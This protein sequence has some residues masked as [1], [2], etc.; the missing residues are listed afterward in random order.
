[1]ARGKNP[2]M[3]YYVSARKSWTRFLF[4]ASWM[5]FACV[6]AATAQSMKRSDSG[7]ACK[8]GKR[9]IVYR[10][11]FELKRKNYPRNGKTLMQWNEIIE[12]LLVTHCNK[13]C[14]FSGFL[15]APHSLPSS[16]LA[17]GKI[18]RTYWESWHRICNIRLSGEHTECIG[19]FD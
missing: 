6:A 11:L 7:G 16:S 5:L 10:N 4:Q 8:R 14:A 13:S 17:F 3:K 19:W 12:I 2:S 18:F 1:M 9:W 15:C